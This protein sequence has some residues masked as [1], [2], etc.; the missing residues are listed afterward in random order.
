MIDALAA[1]SDP[2]SNAALSVAGKRYASR[3]ANKLLAED[4]TMSARQLVELLRTEVVSQ[5]SPK[6]DAQVYT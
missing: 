3:R 4:T 2:G 6:R 1:L 5:I